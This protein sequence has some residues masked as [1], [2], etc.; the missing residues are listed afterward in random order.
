[1][2][3]EPHYRNVGSPALGDDGGGGGEG[4]LELPEDDGKVCPD[5]C[6]R[7]VDGEDAVL[8]P[9]QLGRLF[10]KKQKLVLASRWDEGGG[11]K[12]TRFWYC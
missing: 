9:L 10:H 5:R 12:V 8:Q 3:G 4:S 2:C 11:G 7:G 1:M 6:L